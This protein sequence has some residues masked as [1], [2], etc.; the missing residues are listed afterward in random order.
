MLQQPSEAMA[1]PSMPSPLTSKDLQHLFDFT[2]KWNDISS[3]ATI[4]CC[5]GVLLSCSLTPRWDHRPAVDTFDYD[6]SHMSGAF[7]WSSAISFTSAILLG[8]DV[9]CMMK[10]KNIQSEF[11]DM[12]AF[13]DSVLMFLTYV[14]LA[15]FYSFMA[16]SEWSFV[17]ID[18]LANGGPRPVFTVRYC[19]WCCCVPCLMFVGGRQKK[20]DVTETVNELLQSP[21]RREPSAFIWRDLFQALQTAIADSPLSSS[22]RLTVIYIFSSWLA[23]VVQDHFSR[24]LLICLSF[25]DYLIAS[26]QEVVLLLMRRED[27]GATGW[28]TG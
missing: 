28:P 1:V 17:H 18:E 14:F 9:V 4:I 20:R 15:F 13:V 11:E 19:Q 24:W 6:F 2:R 7:Q 27:T 22:I 21:K 23:L 25:S 8:V 12:D 5:V 3:I 16:I 26:L 10:L